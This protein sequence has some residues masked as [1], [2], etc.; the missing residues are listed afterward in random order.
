MPKEKIEAANYGTIEDIV[1]ALNSHVGFLRDNVNFNIHP[2][3]RKVAVACTRPH[4][5]GLYLTPKLSLMLGFEPNQNI[6]N[7]TTPYPS[8]ILLGIGTV[9][10]LFSPETTQPQEKT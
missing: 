10:L 8:N 4:L 5:V 9:T 1:T 7:K 3:L 2:G 6:F